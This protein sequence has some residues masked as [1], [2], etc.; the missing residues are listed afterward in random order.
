MPWTVEALVAKALSIPGNI[1]IAATYN[2]PTVQIEY[3]L[4]VFK[5]CRA[6]GL[7]TVFVSN[8][9]LQKEPLEE[10]LEVTDA[11]NIDLK[12]FTEAFYWNQCGGHLEVVKQVIEQIYG[13]AH[14][15][16]SC[17]LIDG[18]NDSSELLEAQFAFLGGISSEIPVHI[19][20]AFPRYLETAPMTP[21]ETLEGAKA[22]AS[23][24]LK[25]VYLGNVNFGD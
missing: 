1:G 24:Y 19:S 13:R 17:L 6:V 4:D 22:I 2:E 12:G 9:Y 14:L 25:Y 3:V 20:R 11:F 16:V 21:I 8:G 5:A 15:E 23:Q 10:L 18:K 7:K